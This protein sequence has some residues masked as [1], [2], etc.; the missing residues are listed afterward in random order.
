MG[1][2]KDGKR[3]KGLPPF[4]RF[5]GLRRTK[6]GFEIGQKSLLLIFAFAQVTGAAFGSDWRKCPIYQDTKGK[7][8]L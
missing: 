8:T 3:E 6:N 2:K 4:G 1:R 7:E 5:A